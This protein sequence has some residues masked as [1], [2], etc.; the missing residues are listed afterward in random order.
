MRKWS[1]CDVGV[2]AIT[3]WLVLVVTAGAETCKLEIKQLTPAVGA[4]S[5]DILPS[6]WFESTYPQ[7]V[8]MQ[9]GGPE[10][11]VPGSNQKGIPEF[12]KVV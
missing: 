10:G 9:V 7:S 5:G 4:R 1:W 3:G 12:S 2:V 8:H 11:T 6:Y